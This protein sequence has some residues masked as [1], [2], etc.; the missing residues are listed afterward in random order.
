MSEKDLSEQPVGPGGRKTRTA[1]ITGA[2][3]GIGRETVGALIGAGYRVLLACRNPELGARVATELCMDDPE[4]DR[5][6]VVSCDLASFDSIRRAAAEVGSLTDRLDLLVNNA[7]IM[8]SQRSFTV[9]GYEETFAVN[10]LGPFLLTHLLLPL[11]ST[12]RIVNVASRAHF[13][14]R[15]DPRTVTDREAPF[16]GMRAYSQS[17]LANVAFTLTLAERLGD[18][19]VT[20]NCLHPGVVATNIASGPG[21]AAWGFRLMSPFL[22]SAREGAQ[23]SIYLALDPAIPGT[24]GYFNQHQ[25]RK[26]PSKAARDA[27]MRDRIWAFCAECTSVGTS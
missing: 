18:A 13:R 21:L 20:V 5:V 10:Q 23:T 16:N 4:P 9:D 19:P 7:G 25:R 11:M 26:A 22:L 3:H 6:R 24:G 17:K 8:A 2:T 1:L 12:G 15:F 27:D 14:G